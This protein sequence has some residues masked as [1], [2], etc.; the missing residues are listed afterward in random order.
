MKDFINE[1][2]HKVFVLQMYQ[3]KKWLLVSVCYFFSISVS[4]YYCLELLLFI[5]CLIILNY[6]C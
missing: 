2:V 3:L 4:I 5:Y 1:P 6:K